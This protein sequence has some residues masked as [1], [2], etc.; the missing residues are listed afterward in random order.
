MNLSNRTS[1]YKNVT[2]VMALSGIKAT[3]MEVTEFLSNFD[4]LSAE[5][6]E[7]LMIAMVEA[8]ATKIKSK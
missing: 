4:K 7:S 1:I 5:T 6:L 2:E 8:M 3:P